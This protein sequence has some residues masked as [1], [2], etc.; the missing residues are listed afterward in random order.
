MNIFRK[1]YEAFFKKG[2]VKIN[3]NVVS[4]YGDLSIQ[5]LYS[6]IQ[7]VKN[8]AQDRQQ[9]LAEYRSM[10]AD[11][12]TLSAVELMAEDATQTDPDTGFSV[13]ISCP[14]FPELEKE[15][16]DFLH[17]NFNSEIN[18]YAIAFNIIA[19]GDAYIS[20]FY[21]DEAYKLAGNRV[22]DY[23]EI[24]TSEFVTHLFHYGKPAGF[25][26]KKNENSSR[27]Q[28]DEQII[29]DEKDFIHFSADNGLNY[30]KIS[31]ESINNNGSISSQA[32]TVKYGN[33]F[34]EA[35]RS[36]YKT[37]NLFKDLMMLARLTRSQFYRLVSVDVGQA[38]DRET[39]RMIKE[40]RDVISNSQ[41]IQ[42]KIGINTL[43][44]PMSTGGNV[45]FPTR[46]GK[47]SVSME[48]VGG[49]FNVS[50]MADL[51]Y[52]DNQ[53]MAAL[54][55]PKQFLGQSEDLPSGLGES[56]LTRLDIRYARTVKRIQ[57]ILADGI[58]KLILWKFQLDNLDSIINNNYEINSIP[59][60]QICFHPVSSAESVERAEL[61]EQ[62]TNKV[63]KL[64]D[65]L[66]KI[67]PDNKINRLDILPFLV[68]NMALNKNLAN[69]IKKY[70]YQN[71]NQN[72]NL[73]SNDNNI[74]DSFNHHNNLNKF[75]SSISKIKNTK[76]NL[77]DNLN[78]DY[79]LYQLDK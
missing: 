69:M 48:T 14:D 29:L 31:V 43:S 3:S 75:K 62:Q 10:L 24:D 56:S 54:K 32:Y 25:L 63:E 7:D 77:N 55:V 18:L 22:G 68:D 51:D 47:G 1:I 6:I 50:E 57:K 65:I 42:P 30:A 74:N 40:V 38:D 12:T 13:W 34:L 19:F 17:Y 73:N 11:G 58:R 78:D 26:V 5:D 36:Y 33:S 71:N 67:D 60:F 44:S 79:F 37:I 20:T 9:R 4:S 49:D 61:I 8:I 45:Y 21:S 66:D 28:F 52:F 59:D 46:N 15:M 72:N 16:N 39:T 23:F 41:T 70:I 35:A 76:Q 64:L 2:N 53:Y 27:D